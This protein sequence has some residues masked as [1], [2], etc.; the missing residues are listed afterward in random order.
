LHNSRCPYLQFIAGA[1]LERFDLP[2]LPA[3]GAVSVTA[4][5]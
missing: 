4:G 2:H 5:F 3:G 1:R